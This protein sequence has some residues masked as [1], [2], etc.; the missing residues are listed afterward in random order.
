MSAVGRLLDL[1]LASRRASARV[2][3]AR[4]TACRGSARRRR[5]R[6]P[7]RP[8]SRRSRRRSPAAGGTLPA[9]RVTRARRAGR[10]RRPPVPSLPA[11]SSTPAPATP[12]RHVQVAAQEGQVAGQARQAGIGCPG[13]VVESPLP[14][15]RTARPPCPAPRTQRSPA[16]LH[17]ATSRQQVLADTHGCDAVIAIAPTD[18]QRQ[19]DED[20]QRS[21]RPTT[22]RPP[23]L[24]GFSGTS[25]RMGVTWVVVM[26]SG[27][28]RVPRQATGSGGRCIGPWSKVRGR[29]LTAGGRT[30][31]LGGRSGARC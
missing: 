25:L 2:P 9:E 27:G 19:H 4:S 31:A 1:S 7:R 10:P 6:A 13:R 16:L 15:R 17:R 3:R 26:G 23:A 29:P 14:P 5:S 12:A 11:A 18:E 24:G 8:R 28:T 21:G 30:T 22:E 20:R